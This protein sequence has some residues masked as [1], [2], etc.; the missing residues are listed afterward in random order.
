MLS[1]RAGKQVLPEHRKCCVTEMRTVWLNTFALVAVLTS[2]TLV[3]VHNFEGDKSLVRV[4]FSILIGVALSILLF[5]P[6]AARLKSSE[7]VVSDEGVVRER[8]PTDGGAVDMVISDLEGEL[9]FGA[10]PELDQ[11][12][13][14]L[15]RQIRETEVSFAIIRVKRTR[16][17]DMVCMERFEHFLRETKRFGVTVLLCGIRPDFDTAMANLQFEKWLPAE[18]LFREEDETYSATLR[19]VRYAYQRLGRQPAR[20]NGN[21]PTEATRAGLYYLV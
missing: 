3:I 21:P 10:A 12:F 8:L 7:L 14:N 5:I 1:A 11:Y 17:P 18:Q 19:A 20:K 15:W 4:E 13:S 2:A 16:N 6:R 9:F